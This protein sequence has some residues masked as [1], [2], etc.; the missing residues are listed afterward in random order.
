MP[1]AS[2]HVRY[3]SLAATLP[4]LVLVSALAF[5]DDA[6]PV[7]QI[8]KGVT[9]PKLLHKVE[10]EFSLEAENARIQGSAVYSI[11]VGKNGRPR[12]I[13]LLSPI[14]YGLDEK[15]IEAIQKWVF[16]PGTK[17]GMPVSVR[18]TIE[19][20]FR[21]GGVAFDSKAEEWRAAYNAALHNLQIADRKVRAAESIRLLADHQ[22]PPAMSLL[23][24]WM[25]EGR[26]VPKDLPA[27][28]DLLKKAADKNDSNGLYVLGALYMDGSGVT[29]DADKGL[30]LIREASTYGSPRAQFYLGTIYE[31]GDATIAA[32][33]ERARRYYRLCAAGGTPLCQ[34]HLG[35]LLMP[36]PGASK[37]DPVQAAAWLEL[38]RDASVTEAAPLALS[39]RA[40]MSPEQIQQVERLKPQLLRR[41]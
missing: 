3:W 9:A 4:L 26:D 29:A 41:R 16:T 32:D 2:T 21:L 11:V 27:G 23:G 17:D 8:G 25:V 31:S 37:G 34:L 24:E 39:L 22:Y 15:G 35:K 7:F 5:A 36:G 40:Q 19:V 14:G 38:A 13:E 33:P 6:D 12:N 28:I 30:K 18:A 1:T 10:P 20:N